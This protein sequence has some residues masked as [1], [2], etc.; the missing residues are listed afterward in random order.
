MGPTKTKSIELNQEQPIFKNL[1]SEPK[2]KHI[3]QNTQNIIKQSMQFF[4]K[5]KQNDLLNACTE[6]ILIKV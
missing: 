1:K 5:N 3:S 4:K 2:I 6:N